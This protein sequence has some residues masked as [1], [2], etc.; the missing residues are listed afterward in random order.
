[1][2]A[3]DSTCYF[4]IWVYIDVLLQELE[5]IMLESSVILMQ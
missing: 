1:M 5:S 4:Y 2:V 3:N